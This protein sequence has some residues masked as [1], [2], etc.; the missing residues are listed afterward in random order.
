VKLADIVHTGKSTTS[1]VGS[2]LS[3]TYYLSCLFAGKLINRL[4]PRPV[5]FLGA[6]LFALGLFLSSWVNELWYLYATYGLVL[7]VGLGMC[8]VSFLTTIGVFFEAHRPI[9]VG[10][11]MTGAGVGGFVMPRVIRVLIDGFGWQGALRIQSVIALGIVCLASLLLRLP[12]KPTEFDLIKS[13]SASSILPL[14]PT[15][16]QQRTFKELLRERSIRI[17]MAAALMWAFGLF[18][19]FTYLVSCSSCGV[20]C[21]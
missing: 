17:Y 5:A 2:I 9:A 13:A 4:G 7:G 21:D 11:Y 14:S 20:C 6:L 18:L 12:R 16:Q 1:W 10:L 15:Q 3:A 8:D 19:P